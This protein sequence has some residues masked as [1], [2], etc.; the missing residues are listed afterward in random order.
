MLATM[1]KKIT[2]VAI[3]T[4]VTIAL[5]GCG[6]GGGGVDWS[7]YDSSVKARIDALEA[8]GDCVGLQTEFDTA[9]A[10]NDAQR[11][12]TGEGNTDL[13]EYLNELMDDTGCYG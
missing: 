7:N 3:A 11:A 13:L 12:R 2:T 8:A 10:N 4:T 5:A 1:G 9:Y 6:G